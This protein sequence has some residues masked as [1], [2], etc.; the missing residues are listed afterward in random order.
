MLP[1]LPKSI[2]FLIGATLL[3]ACAYNRDSNL[4][5]QAMEN[6]QSAVHANIPEK[7]QST[8]AKSDSP[9]RQDWLS[10]FDSPQLAQYV[11][12]ALRDNFDLHSIANRL[13]RAQAL[14][15]TNR[16]KN[17]PNSSI[18]YDARRSKSQ[19]GTIATQ[20]GLESN[21]NWEIDLWGK[22]A[23]SHKSF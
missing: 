23:L 11:E 19:A 18:S 7:W 14:V 8:T 16:A 10:D 17:R 22:L 4:H 6:G 15:I 3:S 21:I 9:I 2:V 1:I 5:A 20:H 12:K 13:E